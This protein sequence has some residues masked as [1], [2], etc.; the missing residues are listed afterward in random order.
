[1]SQSLYTSMGGI[2][3]AQTS[4]NVISNNIAN[5][6]TT[7]FK[8]S[9][10]N[11]S[12]VYSSTLSSG[13]AATATTG[14][15]NPMQVGLG[16]QVSSISKNFTAGTWVATG[17]TTDLMIQGNGFFTVKASGGEIFYTR[18]GD[19][20]FDSDGDL[21]TSDGYKV[22]GTNTILAT[23]SS[24]TA[25]HIPQKIVAK[26]TANE[27][28][29]TRLVS[30][31]NNCQ[32][33]GGKFN[34]TTIT[35]TGVSQD[36]E[37]DLTVDK[38]TTVQNV[39]DSIQTQI[40]TA[41]GGPG[42][43]VVTCVGGTIQFQLNGGTD[44]SSLK[45]KNPE[46][47]ASNF[48]NEAGLTTAALKDN[49]YTGSVL[50]YRASVTQV[51]SVGDAVSINSYSIGDDGSIEATYSNGDTISVEVGADKTTYQF[52]YTTAEGIKIEGTNVTVDTNVAKE[53]N[54]VIQLASITNPDGLISEGSNLYSAGPNTG[55]ILYSIGDAMGLGAIASGGLEASNVDLSEEFSNMILA[56]R[57][58]QANSRVF[59]TTSD[60]MDTVVNMGR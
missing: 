23:S 7:A 55:D 31:L 24:E 2:S 52:I 11:F 46:T 45:F 29:K 15:I 25:V 8:S 42:H 1:M 35:G 13:T 34:I 30:D 10:A 38:T 50:D 19:F 33:T 18:A 59:S 5:I 57:A 53:A 4:L 51:T 21:V 44:V 47:G 49:K 26:V 28:V 58:V 17:E 41:L 9:K 56:Q 43:V 39:M 16:V 37:I 14:G 12:E 3:A 54:F 48:I 40:N 6:N 32:L 60:I 27:D 22:L 20:S 36:I